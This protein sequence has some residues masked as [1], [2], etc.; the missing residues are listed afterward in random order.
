MLRENH[1]NKINVCQ[2]HDNELHNPKSQQTQN[3]HKYGV[4]KQ[5]SHHIT[6][7]STTSRWQYL[8]VRL[9]KIT[10]KI[11]KITNQSQSTH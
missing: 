10:K 3:Y 6:Q 5:Q 11:S 2:L 7:S 8:V 9:F 4:P 1:N